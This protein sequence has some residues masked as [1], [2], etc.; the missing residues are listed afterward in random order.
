MDA[1]SPDYYF[2]D[3]I[4]WPHITQNVEEFHE[5]AAIHRIDGPFRSPDH[6]SIEYVWE[7]LGTAI[8]HDL[9]LLGPNRN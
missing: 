5:G 8:S 6:N 1:I 2:M 9:L 7:C 3:H 4:A